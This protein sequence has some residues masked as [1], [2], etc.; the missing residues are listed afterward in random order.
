MKKK[1]LLLRADDLDTGRLVTIHHWR[2]GCS[3]GLG[4][5]YRVRAVNLPYAILQPMGNESDRRFTLD[6]RRAVLMPITEAYA[7][8]QSEGPP[9]EA[10]GTARASDRDDVPF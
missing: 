5:A 3:I 8:A 10:E 4:R 6:L 1:G 7:Q 9:A 2:D